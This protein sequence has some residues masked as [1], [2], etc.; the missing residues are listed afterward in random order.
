MN[1]SKEATRVRLSL[2]VDAMEL[3]PGRYRILDALNDRLLSGPGGQGW[4]KA[5]LANIELELPAFGVA[6]LVLRPE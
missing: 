5:D 4:S 3:A 2:P 1:F 6:V